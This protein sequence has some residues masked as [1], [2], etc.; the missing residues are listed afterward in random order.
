[1]FQDVRSQ[2]T[3]AQKQRPAQKLF[4]YSH[5]TDLA[6]SRS[7]IGCIKRTLFH[8]EVTTS[9]PSAGRPPATQPTQIFV[10]RLDLS[11]LVL[12]NRTICA[13]SC[14][15]PNSPINSKRPS[16][17]SFLN[18]IDENRTSLIEICLFVKKSRSESLAR[19]AFGFGP[20]T[21]SSLTGTQSS[22]IST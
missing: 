11:R 4:G 8:L 7:A 9:E 6:V 1:M 19:A 10:R 5:E 16:D 3:N 14:R 2:A 15:H 22:F 13:L 12:T 21:T 20:T 17:Q 18:G